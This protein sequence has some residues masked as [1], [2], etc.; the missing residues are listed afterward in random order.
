[1]YKHS[2][3][4][5][6]GINDDGKPVRSVY[7]VRLPKCGDTADPRPQCLDQIVDPVTPI[8][9]TC[10]ALGADG[11]SELAQLVANARAAFANLGCCTRVSDQRWW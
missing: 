6:L 5:D 3:S 8:F 2:Q 4:K 1:M 11:R 7:L 9:L 10:A